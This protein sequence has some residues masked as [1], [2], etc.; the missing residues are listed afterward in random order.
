MFKIKGTGK[1]SSYMIT[2]I[3]LLL[4]IFSIV[5][6]TT[7]YR[8]FTKYYSNEYSDS[9]YKVGLTAKALINTNRV[10]DYLSENGESE[11]Y[12]LSS[13]RL[14]ILVNNM[15]VSVIYVIIPDDDYKHYTNIFNIVSD[16]SGYDAWKI[17]TRK[18]TSNKLYEKYY[19]QIMQGKKNKATI[20]R[21]KDLNGAKPHLTSLIPL[22]DDEDNITSILCVQRFMGDL[23]DARAKYIFS[24]SIFTIL[25]IVGSIIVARRFIGNQVVAP[26]I[27][28]NNETKR[29]AN[30]EI[31][32]IGDLKKISVISE[33]ESLSIS[34]NKIEKDM[35]KYIENLTDAT[36]EKERI[37]T[38]LKL[39][40]LIQN[41]SLP[42]N[43]PAFPDRDDF[44]LYALMNPAKE[45]GGDF[46]D[47]F[48]IDKNHIGLVMA[49][50][51]GKG[52]PAAL[53]MMVA[54][55]LINEISHSGKSP[56]EVLTLVND[57]ICSNNKTNMF[58]TV[59]LGV[60]NLKTGDMVASNAGHE[61]PAI[62]RKG[63]DFYIDKQKHGIP[64]GAMEEYK[65]KNYNIKLNSGDKLFLYTDG[66]PEAE[67]NIDEMFGLERMINSLN[68]IKDNNCEQILK[69]LKRDINKFVNGAIQFDDLTM[70]CFEYIGINNNVN[71]KSFN[72]D[73]NELDS[74]LSFIHGIVNEK[75]NSK[76]SMKLDVVI[77][78]I[79]VNICHY[80]YDDLGNVDIEVSLGKEK[81][82][83]IFIDTGKKFN[84]LEKEDPNI[85]L[86]SED[87][88]IGGLG[89]FMVKKMMDKVD[90]K[91]K[92]KKNILLVEK[93]IGG[94]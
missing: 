38:E 93:K 50:V 76:E 58:I 63:K 2:S 65:Y 72:S 15:D 16:T 71:K 64:V 5:V 92:D 9:A 68:A 90:Y 19:K 60:L 86:S 6:E 49:D 7:G 1:L 57:R 89:I 40:N 46:Y 27:A 12:K 42:S 39:A 25:S 26:V 54:K 23:K 73:V 45:V 55:I 67:N 53:F 33:I 37:S 32:T 35:I 75:I 61:D 87:R 41:N 66:V 43:F 52:V 44:D 84:P 69:E 34:I 91:Y 28:I 18:E 47:F 77:E 78:E 11:D 30:E 24:I 70:L 13:K 79:F 51:S 17:G 74:V 20:Y 4:I 62:Y 81:L 59:W 36:K 14:Q 56:A 10:N 48:L 31:K 8:L 29:F 21:T 83:I 80:A 88:K 85:K 3:V 94:K 82:T 22:K